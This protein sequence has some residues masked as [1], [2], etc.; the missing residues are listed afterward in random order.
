MTNNNKVAALLTA[1]ITSAI[2]TTNFFAPVIAQETTNATA[3]TTT[4]EQGGQMNTTV[5]RDTSTV[6]LS[7]QTIPSKDYI[8]LY[9]TT[10]YKIMNGHI[11][12][13][14]PC[15][16]NS[17]STLQIVTG[18]APDLKPAPLELIS[19]LSKPGNLCIYHVDIPQGN[20]TTTD[21]AILNPTD[22]QITLPNTSTVVI[23]V[24]EIMPLGGESHHPG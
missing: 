15:D 23:G 18:Q 14:V 4:I 9:D 3:S 13:K 20:T 10:P 17:N 19:E 7:N 11:A 12:A 2:I 22:S 8:H 1:I 5:V 16:A 24:N 6:L 21:I